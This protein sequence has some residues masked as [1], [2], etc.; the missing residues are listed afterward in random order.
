MRAL[1]HDALDALLTEGLFDR[2]E[3]IH[4]QAR[5]G[6]GEMG[7]GARRQRPHFGR[8]P[9]GALLFLVG[10]QLL[11]VQRVEVLSNGHGGDA[12]LRAQGFG[13]ARPLLLEQAQDR[14]P[15][16]NQIGFLASSAAFCHRSKPTVNRF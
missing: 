7:L 10:H 8:P 11:S 2:V 5:M 13:V 14:L 6:I 12:Q 4:G 9:D 1:Q 15:T 3:Q 16:G